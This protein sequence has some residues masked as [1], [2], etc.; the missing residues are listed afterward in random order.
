MSNTAVCFSGEIRSF[1]NNFNNINE[2]NSIISNSCTSERQYPPKV[3][4][5]ST[6]ETTTTFLGVTSYTETLTINSFSY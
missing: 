4:D 3:F 2:M 1:E 6:T 5:S